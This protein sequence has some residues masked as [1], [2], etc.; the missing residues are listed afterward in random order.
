MLGAHQRQEN[1]REQML[2]LPR[3][4]A[5]PGRGTDWERS[6]GRA[7]HWVPVTP[8]GRPRVLRLPDGMV[9]IAPFPLNHPPRN[10][11]SEVA[12]TG[13]IFTSKHGEK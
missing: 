9:L 6:R 10:R 11:G 5:R 13:I 3:D 8:N 4:G 2:T 1:E 7:M 12:E